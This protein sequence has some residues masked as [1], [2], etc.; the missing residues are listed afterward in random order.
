MITRGNTSRNTEEEAY[1]EVKGAHHMYSA[2]T[3]SVVSERLRLMRSESSDMLR[4]NT[5]TKQRL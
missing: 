4:R 5:N 3:L 2:I 1:E